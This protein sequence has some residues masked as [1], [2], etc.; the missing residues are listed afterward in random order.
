MRKRVRV[1]ELMRGMYVQ[2]A[3]ASCVNSKKK[4][5]L[6]NPMCAAILPTGSRII[7]VSFIARKEVPHAI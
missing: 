6:G 1:E 2:E 7:S 3:I 5:G 4:E